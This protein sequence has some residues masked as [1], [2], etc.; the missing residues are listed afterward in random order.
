MILRARLALD[1]KLEE[2]HSPCEALST[3]EGRFPAGT[4]GRRAQSGSQHSAQLPRRARVALPF[5]GKKAAKAVDH[6]N[7]VDMSAELIR[8]FLADLETSRH[9]AIVTR[10]QRLA[11]IHALARF[12]GEHSPERIPLCAQLRG[13]H[14]RSENPVNS[15]AHLAF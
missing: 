2:I 10:N 13:C 8:L 7:V 4:S 12:V 1:R 3:P 6:L 11:A 5:V 14:Q 9:C 15:T